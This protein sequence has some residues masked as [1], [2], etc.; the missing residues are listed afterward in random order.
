MLPPDCCNQ[1]CPLKTAE[2][3]P[4]P[5]RLDMQV[6][7]LIKLAIFTSQLTFSPH[8]VIFACIN[9]V[10]LSR[11]TAHTTVDIARLS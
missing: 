5:V 10:E 6:S 8:A 3:A 4:A 1:A 7:Y 9:A 11:L 2:A